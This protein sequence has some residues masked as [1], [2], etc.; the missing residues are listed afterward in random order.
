MGIV[1][2]VAV[3]AHLPEKVRISKNKKRGFFQDKLKTE[4]ILF[5]ISRIR[6][7]EKIIAKEGKTRSI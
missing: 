5:R 4:K 1:V 2:A 7:F 3:L 6:E